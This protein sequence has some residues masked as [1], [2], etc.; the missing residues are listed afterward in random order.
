MRPLA[1]MTLALLLPTP[2]AAADDLLARMTAVNANLHSFTAQMKAHV[3]LT[4]F[5]FLS[6][7]VDG[8]LYH[9]DPD[10]NKVEITSGLPAIA[11]NFDKLYPQIEPPS[12][13][14][15]VFTLEKVGDDGKT[16]TFELTPK[17]NGNIRSIT[18][19][20]D[21]ASALVR[22]MRWSYQNGASATMDNTYSQRGGYWLI[23][24][25]AGSVDE[26]SYKGTIS[27]TISN[28]KINP[29]LDDAIF[30]P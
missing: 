27:S 28:Y 3:A 30:R 16:T 6:A 1:I 23:T 13:W 5:P 22:S 7:D 20:V 11:K 17:V 21:D 25:Q 9:K 4:T 19:S 2:T 12:R 15:Q 8:T 18:A 29:P 10:M 24:A 26:P 14:A